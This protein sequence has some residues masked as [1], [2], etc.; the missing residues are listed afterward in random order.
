[1]RCWLRL[2][3]SIRWDRASCGSLPAFG[4]SHQSSSIFRMSISYF[5][6]L[7]TFTTGGFRP[8]C[9]L[10]VATSVFW[11]PIPSSICPAGEASSVS[12]LCGTMAWWYIR[13]MQ[14]TSSRPVHQFWLTQR[15][16]AHLFLCRRDERCPGVSGWWMRSSGRSPT[17]FRCG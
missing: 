8:L 1:M 9:F 12:P 17:W 11:P 14:R 16:Y 10:F 2:V 7:I 4:P 3:L 15:E 5:F 13:V 6:T